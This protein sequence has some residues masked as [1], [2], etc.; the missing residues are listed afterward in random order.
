MR[1][2]KE[3][4]S[5]SSDKLE[6]YFKDVETLEERS[7]VEE[8]EVGEN[9]EIE[10]VFLKG[11]SHT[12]DPVRLYL[13]EM[14]AA[15]LLTRAG[16]VELAK[17]IER[18]RACV[19]RAI[20]KTLLATKEILSLGKILEEKP[21]LFTEVFEFEENNTSELS[22]K[23]KKIKE[24]IGKLKRLHSRLEYIP[25]DK[26]FSFARGRVM[27]QIAGVLRSLN[28]HSE[29]WEKIAGILRHKLRVMDKLEEEKED[30]Q[31]NIHKWGNNDRKKA[32][33]RE[34]RRIQKLLWKERK[35]VG[36]ESRSLRK[37][38]RDIA[39]GEKKAEKAKKELVVANLRLVISIA[40]KYTNR[41]MKFL[42]L[43]QEGNIGLMRAVDKFDY[44][45]GYK[46]STYA[47]WW[48]KQAITRA[49]AEQ[50]RT[51]RVPVHMVEAISKVKRA[52]QSLIQSLGREPTAQEIAEKT[53]LPE[54]KVRKI[55]E[56]DQDT[57]S[58]E[59]PIGEEED[60]HLGDFIEDKKNPSP[61]EAA[62]QAN[63]KEIISEAL[64]TLTERE[65]EVLRM[66]FGLSDGNEHTL[67]EVGQRF[68]V[69]RERIRQIEAKALRKLKQS[70]RGRQL[71]SFVLN[72]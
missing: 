39:A 19:V 36:L 71:M 47:T 46:F 21:E 8:L 4:K 62:I 64:N 17:Q 20:S 72:N 66:R 6:D 68:K 44:R 52:S 28:I 29:Y 50:S 37:I 24:S 9:S 53:G 13:K 16:E 65:A 38:L 32:L 41:G 42:D 25:R 63:L 35:E 3:I 61:P 49:I 67:E 14:G 51:V 15:H 11:L 10:G 27:V 30:L 59:T 43:I 54:E 70:S 22:E 57:V 33:E 56:A 69:T 31:V 40:K 2:N 48:I 26:K 58:L 7:P 5:I 55:I 23:R 18:G 1:V 45:R 12:T 34:I 60:S